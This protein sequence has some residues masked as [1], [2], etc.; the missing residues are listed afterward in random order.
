MAVFENEN[1]V[2]KSGFR[3]CRPRGEGWMVMLQGNYEYK[4]K[5]EQH[6]HISNITYHGDIDDFENDDWITLRHDFPERIDYADMKG[7]AMH[8]HVN[9]GTDL[10]N[11]TWPSDVLTIEPY[12]YHVDK[13]KSPFS[14]KYAFSGK[15]NTEN[16]QID[17]KYGAAYTMGENFMISPNF[18]KCFF[19][20]CIVPEPAPPTAP[21]TLVK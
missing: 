14:V 1:G 9:N 7:M 15:D 4:M 6:E 12:S 10:S 13:D 18:Y 20:D 5:F 11:G 17:P 16:P 21:P 19:K 8:T 2:T 3:N